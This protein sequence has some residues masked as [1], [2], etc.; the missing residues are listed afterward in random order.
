MNTA[1]PIEILRPTGLGHG[2]SQPL[3]LQVRESLREAI[4]LHF[5]DGQT[6]W[7]EML[8]IER[9]GVSRITVRHA[10]SELTREGLLVRRTSQGTTVRKTAANSIGVIFPRINSD[11][12][13]EILHQISVECLKR[14]LH[15]ELYPT[16]GGAR[17][18]SIA[19]GIKRPAQQ[20]RL[21]LMTESQE[22]KG[23]LSHTLRE[24]GYR[25]VALGKPVPGYEGALVETDAREAVRLAYRHL[26]ELGHERIA[27][28][29]N[30]PYDNVSV[31]D[32]LAEYERL[33]K[34]AETAAILVTKLGIEHLDS[35]E[36][37]Y[38]MMPALWAQKPTAIFTASDPGAWAALRWFAERN[39]KV[40]DE[41]SVVGFEGV[42]P[43]SFT[44]PPLTTVAHD[45]EEIARRAL[46]LLWQDSPVQ[47]LVPPQV[48]RRQSTAPFQP[49]RTV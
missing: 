46:E 22:E 8:L 24:R 32:K 37:A 3:H 34:G 13:T 10:L 48:V 40:P 28:L 9:L 1:P 14:D 6:F 41:V 18:D 45:F 44:F 25:T 21:I 33:T 31:Q 42:K 15:L 5:E 49:S 17:S 16:F 29:V 2:P 26:R 36:S 39:I 11:Y 38:A 35:F 4:D 19:A 43:D 20:E 23:G 12:L 7:T 47:V 27:F 30:E